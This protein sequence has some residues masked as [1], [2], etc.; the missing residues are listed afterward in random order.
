[1]GA[2]V[3]TL[4]SRRV[5][6]IDDE[7]TVGM[8]LRRILSDHTVTVVTGGHD[9]MDLLSSGVLYDMIL[10]DITMPAMSGIEL[11]HEVALQWPDAASRMVFL[12]GGVFTPSD[13][14]FLDEVANERVEKPFDMKRI[15]ALVSSCEPS[16]PP[17]CA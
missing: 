4:E 13:C 7:P 16:N 12:T 5:L 14:A 8:V 1:M 10:C 17:R 15:R 2:A 11:Y 3:V 6:V 9:A